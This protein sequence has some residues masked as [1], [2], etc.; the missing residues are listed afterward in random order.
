[1]YSDTHFHFQKLT[2]NDPETG[3]QILS[4]MVN[5]R[6]VFALDIGVRC[7]DL[8]GRLLHN[9]PCYGRKIFVFYCGNLA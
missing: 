6:P 7:D 2:D 9:N 4:D 5:S 1:M 3:A 8:E